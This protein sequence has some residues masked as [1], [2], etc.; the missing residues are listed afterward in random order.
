MKKILLVL[1]ISLLST[2]Q[3]QNPVRPGEWTTVREYGHS[4]NVN[5]FTE[6]EYDWISSHYNLFTIEKRHAY[7]NYLDLGRATSEIAS[8]ATAAKLLAN[9]SLMQ[10]LFYWNIKVVYEEIYQTI[11]DALAI[12]PEWVGD[13]GWSYDDP[14][15]KAWMID[16]LTQWGTESGHAGVFLDQVQA[17]QGPEE[18]IFEIM[19]STPGIVIYNGY[20]PRGTSD[21]PVIAATAEYLKYS[22]GVYIEHFLHGSHCKYLSQRKALMDSLLAAPK[23]K[24]LIALCSE[25]TTYWNAPDHKL[26][27]A[28]YLIIAN[29]N[30]YYHYVP[31][32]L[33]V[34]DNMKYWSEDFEKPLGPP[35][36]DATVNGY[37]YTRTF[38]NA[39]VRL[40]LKNATSSINWIDNSVSAYEPIAN[41][42]LLGTATQSSVL[43][44]GEASRANDGDTDGVF[45]N[46]S[47]THTAIESQP[48]WMVDLGANYHIGEIS[49]YNRA[50]ESTLAR[51]SNFTVYVLDEDSVV[52]DST[53]YTTAPDPSV[54][55]DA[56][57]VEGRFVK[58]QLNGS[59]VLNLAEVTVAEVK[60]P[61][62]LHEI[63]INILDHASDDSV[64]EASLLIN[65][66]IYTSNY[67]GEMLLEL[68]E[69][70]YPYTLSKKNYYSYN[71]TLLI[72]KDTA[73]ILQMTEK[74]QYTLSYKVTDKASSEDLAQVGFGVASYWLATDVLGEVSCTLYEGEYAY[75]LSKN[76]YILVED[77]L[78]LIK[79]T[80]VSI[81]MDKESY[82]MTFQVKD[83][84]ANE[85]IQEASVAIND[86]L[87]ITD[88]QGELTLVLDYGEYDYKVTKDGYDGD[89]A[90]LF[91]SQDSLV[92]VLLSLET[93]L[94][95]LEA[96]GV[97]IHPNPISNVLMID[98]GKTPMAWY[99]IF[100]ITG[101]SVLTGSIS[102]GNNRIAVDA[103]AEGIYFVK[104]LQDEVLT[105]TKIVKRN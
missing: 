41:L 85:S 54:T 75:S 43:H 51:L 20:T 14:A 30:S 102:Q 58:V 31:R 76:G 83:A 27:L 52:V 10:P 34:S 65:D 72:T 2:V 60:L 78:N 94:N 1:F 6:D 90:T 24:I 69:G 101:E 15:C 35:L 81:Q 104:V 38:E 73:I 7:L 42:A 91:L 23:D 79:D 97:A 32:G 103:L 18:D 67:V 17:F 66:H 45:G 80:L 25:D 44:S 74:P 8:V 87:Y 4:Y 11:Q 26:S 37:V 53:I 19:E 9:D 61:V 13:N 56:G 57:G 46:G 71:D 86:S 3:G 63:A 100:S 93:G 16:V 50:G 36:A 92:S 62:D 99:E 40:D 88:E 59:G 5:D 21:R 105:C 77:T 49:V 33:L 84:S 39:Y 22:D 70:E 64:T 47:V 95:R 82:S 68:P 96:R 48:W 98:I 55:T 29:E 12:H 28:G 89:S